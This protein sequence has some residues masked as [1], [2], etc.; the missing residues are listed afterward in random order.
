MSAI[1]HYLTDPQAILH[2]VSRCL[3]ADGTVA[4]DVWTLESGYNDGCN[5]DVP[6]FMQARPRDLWIPND[7]G[8]RKMAHK[9]F[10]LVDMT[11]PALS[12]DDSHRDIYHLEIPEPKPP[13]RAAIIYGPGG[14]GK[15]TLAASMYEY[16]HCQLDASFV[17]WCRM[18]KEPITSVKQMADAAYGQDETNKEYLQHTVGFVT[19][20]LASRINRDVVIEGYDMIYGPVRSAVLT[21]LAQQWQDIERIELG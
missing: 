16:D 11:G 21:L 15:T 3:A 10:G 4:L 13:A 2:Q 5:E 7:A 20:W 18:K 6:T 14:S 17:K 1:F 19:N 12:P 9:H 8:F